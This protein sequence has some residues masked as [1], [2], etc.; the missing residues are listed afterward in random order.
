M[1][2]NVFFFLK[3]KKDVIFFYDDFTIE[4]GLQLMQKHRFTAMPV[5]DHDGIYLGTINEGD[6]LRYFLTHNDTAPEH[7]MGT[8]VKHLLR[9][10][11]NPSVTVETPVDEIFQHSL[12]Q[13]FVPI[14]DDRQ[15]FIGIVTRKTI[16]AYLL[17][18]AKKYIPLIQ[19]QL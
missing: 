3:M 1:E 8:E 12:N 6:F 7:L 18:E 14:T 10:G 2:L 17:E 13:N 15:I 4:E 5:V 11:F 19:D 9:E 16:L